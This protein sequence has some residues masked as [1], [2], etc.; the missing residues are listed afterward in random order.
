LRVIFSRERI[1]Q[2]V[3]RLAGEISTDYDG[4]PLHVIVVLKGAF[5]F[6]ADL[7][8]RITSPLIIDFVEIASYIGTDSTGRV[9]VARDIALDIRGHHVLVVED[10]VDEGRC[11]SFLLE[12]LR[13]K[14]PASLKVCTLIDNRRRR[15]VSIEPEYVGIRCV[16][17]FLVGYGLDM[18]QRYRELPELYELDPVEGAHEAASS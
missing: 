4:H 17:G 13:G 10:I 12:N 16:C 9:T 11:L 7:V 18:D 15:S 8:R 2:E 1:E 3:E 6:A 5:I 14:M